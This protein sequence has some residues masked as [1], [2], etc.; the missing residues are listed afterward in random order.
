MV[1]V[2]G[3]NAAREFLLRHSIAQQEADDVWTAFAL[4]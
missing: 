1:P 2:D 4:Q 3:A